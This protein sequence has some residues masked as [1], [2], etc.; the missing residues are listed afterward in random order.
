MLNQEVIRLIAK[1]DVYSGY[2]FDS[3]SSSLQ[4][5]GNLVTMQWWDEIWLNEAFATYFQTLPVSATF[6]DWQMVSGEGRYVQN[7][8]RA[9]KLSKFVSS[10]TVHE[11]Y[12]PR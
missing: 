7:Y 6:P 4:W 1:I 3:N 9:H 8:H 11:Y 5:F 10:L 12:Y 2:D